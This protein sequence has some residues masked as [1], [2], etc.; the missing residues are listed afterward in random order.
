MLEGVGT[1]AVLAPIASRAGQGGQLQSG[2]LQGE[3]GWRAMSRAIRKSPCGRGVPHQCPHSLVLPVQLICAICCCYPANPPPVL[4]RPSSALPSAPAALSWTLSLS[5]QRSS[6]CF[7][8]CLPLQARQPLAVTVIRLFSVLTPSQDGLH[9]LSCP[10]SSRRTA[11]V[12]LLLSLHH[13]H[14]SSDL[15]YM[16][17]G[18]N[19]S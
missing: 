13:K 12:L 5:G 2:L 15:V 14:D 7:A 1:L 3:R 4:T 18:P 11:A 19:S 17:V 10:S 8:L 6:D 16:A 9:G